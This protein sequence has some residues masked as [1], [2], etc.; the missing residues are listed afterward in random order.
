[1]KEEKYAKLSFEKDKILYYKGRILPSQQTHSISTMTD[2]MLDLS[3]TT[4]CV[5]LVLKSSPLA[6]SIVD[7]I[8]WHHEI[9]LHSGVET[10]LRYTMKYAY[11]LEGR[12]LVESSKKSCIRCKILAKRALQ[13]SMGPV[14]DYQLTI[15]PAY[16]VSQSDIVGPFKGFSYH[17]KRT[18]I[19]IWFVVFCCV[20]T[21]STTIKVMEDYGTSSFIQAF[22]R[23][24]CEV[25]YP[26]AILIDEGSQLKK[27]CDTMLFNFQDIKMKL[28][29]DCQVEFQ[30]CPV[31]GHNFH[32]KVERKIRSIR[33]SIEKPLRKKG[34]LFYNGKLFVLKYQIRLTICQLLCQSQQEIWNMLTY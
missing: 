7:E 16:Y 26:K 14:S 25:G 13:V 15:A 19:K 2:V 30:T 9:A 4:F 20:A 18:T 32:G 29:K 31:G 12:G 3:Q 21:S 10:I 17:N 1:M 27:G 11:I 34:F 8:H 5:P 28:S 33:E 24:S 6:K 23:F 22:I